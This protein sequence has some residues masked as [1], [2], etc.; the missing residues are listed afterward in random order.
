MMNAL[1]IVC[2]SVCG[3]L[4]MFLLGM[5]HLSDGLQG[6]SG[7]GL[8]HFMQLATL[9][10]MAG[11]ATGAVATLLMQSS[12]IVTVMLVG[13]VT[14]RL[15]TLT[16]SIYVL[17]GANI[18]TTFTI[19]LMAFAPS[20]ELLGLGTLTLGM[21][22]YYPFRKGKIRHIGRAM[23][24][25][26]LVFLGMYFMKQGV[27]PI[28]SSPALTNALAALDATSIGGVFLVATASMVLTAVI[29]SSAAS[30]LIFMTFASQG[31]VSYE[32]AVAALF[33]ANIGTTATLWLAT[34][35]S[36]G[37]AARRL[38]FAHTLT[39]LFGSL[40]CI[41][42]ALSVFVPL[43]KWLFPDWATRVMVPIAITDTVFSLVR[44]IIVFPFA[45]QISR[46]LEW[47]VPEKTDEKPHL[48]AFTASGRLSPVI[49]CEQAAEEVWFM[50]ESVTDLMAHVRLALTGD[51]D[52]KTVKHIYRR[53]EVLD[54]IQGEVTTFLGE[55]MLRSLPSAT[56][57]LARRL[58]RL[59]DELE[60]ASDEA[61]AILRGLDR[62]KAE[63][64]ELSGSDLAMI[65][66][67]HDHAERMTHFTRTDLQAF[68]SLGEWTQLSADLKKR[69]TDARQMQLMR[70]GGS[71]SSAASVLAALDILNAYDRIRSYAMNIAETCAG[72]KIA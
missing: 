18:G 66:D 41:P 67:I 43:G 22:C 45:K 29:Q 47:L 23:V 49:A 46:F 30:I 32:T 26:G 10:R 69:V 39:N 12:S 13:F 58:L 6:A 17:I 20:P 38:A 8:R 71:G 63:G 65:L 25:L 60:S 7:E 72:G 52:E 62:I 70:V 14:S 24:G 50:A 57:R 64:D 56:A 36:G 11:V 33:G 21:L 42:L 59:A 55:V 16:E 44:G 48:S 40:I 37:S 27:E 28:K 15:M 34:I 54:N 51:A 3:G 2:A 61:P 4:G 1:W 53:E 31:L 9:R 5:R 35:G 19:W 68:P